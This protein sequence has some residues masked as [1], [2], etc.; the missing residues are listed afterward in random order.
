MNADTLEDGEISPKK[1][2]LPEVQLEQYIARKTEVGNI[3][4]NFTD[5]KAVL[6][7]ADGTD[8]TVPIYQTLKARIKNG[9]DISKLLRGTMEKYVTNVDKK[10]SEVTE[11]QLF[12]PEHREL[13]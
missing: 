4:R 8:V 1:R 2:R 3:M 6:V 13:A 9:E 12:V 10:R 5:K 11:K 7:A